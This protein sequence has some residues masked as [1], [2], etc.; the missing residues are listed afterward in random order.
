MN[1]CYFPLSVFI[2]SLHSFSMIEHKLMLKIVVKY[3]RF[4][5]E[6]LYRAW[7]GKLYLILKKELPFPQREGRQVGVGNPLHFAICLFH[8]KAKAWVLKLRQTRVR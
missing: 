1:S 2:H 4:N 5:Y 6:E 8:R 3:Y 7:Q